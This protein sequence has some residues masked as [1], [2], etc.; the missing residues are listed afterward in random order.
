MRWLLVLV[1]LLLTGC[2]AELLGPP[3]VTTR[4]VTCAILDPQREVGITWYTPAGEL[5]TTALAA[6]DTWTA[7]VGNMTGREAEAFT[8]QTDEPPPRPWDVLTLATWAQTRPVLD[9][10]LV[11]IHV[12]WLPEIGEPGR[13]VLPVAPGV[14][15]INSTVGHDL[16]TVTGL[17][18][19]GAGHM[20]GIVNRGI[21]MHGPDLSGREGPAGHEPDPDSVMAEAWHR[22]ADLPVNATSDRYSDALIADWQHARGPEGV[23]E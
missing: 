14:I 13:S 23:C 22:V 7:F 9:D 17:L 5:P 2:F 8:V 3:E 20:M 12:L 18:F 15:M 10:G 6:T 16:H 19:H 1:P 11:N 21:P 4:T